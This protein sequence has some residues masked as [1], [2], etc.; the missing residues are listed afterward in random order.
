M[1][2]KHFKIWLIFF[3]KSVL[4]NGE[5]TWKELLK[6]YIDSKKGDG[7]QM[8][9]SILELIIEDYNSDYGHADF[10]YHDEIVA[11]LRKPDKISVESSYI[12]QCLNGAFK[13]IF[14]LRTCI[15]KDKNAHL[16]EADLWDVYRLEIIQLENLYLIS[17]NIKKLSSR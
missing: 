17:K 11:Y 12:D 2:H 6:E 8:N 3:L 15:E 16:A 14:F 4:L 1:T 7:K 10:L 13:V 5:T 9:V